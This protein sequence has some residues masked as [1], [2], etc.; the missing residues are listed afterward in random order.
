VVAWRAAPYRLALRYDRGTLGEYVSFSWPVLVAGGSGIVFA[1]SSALVGE[2]VLGLAGV[3]VIVLAATISDYT[4]RVDAIVTETLY[5]ALC[6][7]RD[8]IDLLEESFVKSNRL[9]LMWGVPFGIGLTLFAPD[10]VDF[11]LGTR[12]RP[13][14]TLI[15]AFG[16]I[17]A[18]SHIGFNWDAFYRARGNT[19]PLAVW[20]A[21][22][23]VA[24]L[25]VAIPLLI[26]DHLNGLA[27]GMGIVTAISLVVRGVYLRRLFPGL[28]IIRHGARA[29][30]PTLSAVAVV[31]LVRFIHGPHRTGRL[32]LGELLLY[33]A[34]AVAAT[35]WVERG[36]LREVR[37]YL[38]GGEAEPSVPREP[39]RFDEPLQP[40]PR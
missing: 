28:R 9:A 13:G 11:V 17:A 33:V 10:V 21:T 8:R 34:V 26:L 24:F 27:V 14:V 20:S 16:A 29:V 37:G 31:L 38:R 3:G 30:A 39:P 23:A 5:P 40:R 6:A 18:I 15:Q 25:V 35:W 19:R 36:L 1:Q 32:A 4:N 7:V 2:K 12:W 22:T